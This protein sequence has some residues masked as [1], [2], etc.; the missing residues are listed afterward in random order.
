MNLPGEVEGVWLFARAGY[1]DH[2]GKFVIQ[3]RFV[4]AASDFSQGFAAFKPGASSWGTSKW[5]YLNKTGNWTIKPQ[6]DN[7]GSFSEGL[8]AVAVFLD[9]KRTSEKWGYIDQAGKV[10]IPAQFDNAGAFQ[11]GI[12]RVFIA[13]KDARFEHLQHPQGNWGWR[14]IDKG[15][16]FVDCPAR[17][18]APNRKSAE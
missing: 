12:A 9:K 18:T 13:A 8:A 4:E 15:G 2:S 6:F 3:P 5:G 1:I 17:P 11:Q 7:A 16:N 14:C 10:V